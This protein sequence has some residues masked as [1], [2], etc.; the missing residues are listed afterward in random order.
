VRDQGCLPE[1]ERITWRTR[2]LEGRHLVEELSMAGREHRHRLATEL[3]E[4]IIAA[5]RD[6]VPER[7]S[8]RAR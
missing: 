6:S 8:A 1:Q 2:N 4:P 3:I 7:R 5:H